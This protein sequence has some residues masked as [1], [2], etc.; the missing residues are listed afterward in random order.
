MSE[1]KKKLFDLFRS[2]NQT[3]KRSQERRDSQVIKMRL[4]LVEYRMINMLLGNSA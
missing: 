3:E 2:S 4:S 1:A